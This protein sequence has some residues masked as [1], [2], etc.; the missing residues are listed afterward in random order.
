MEI[1]QELMDAV[2]K[3]AFSEDLKQDFYVWVLEAEDGSI[4]LDQ[5]PGRL[6]ATVNRYI[7]HMASNEKWKE[8]NRLRLLQENEQTVRDLYTQNDEYA[9]D[10]ADIVGLDQSMKEFLGTLSD[11]YR[12]TFEKL[13]LEGYTPEDL[14][15]EEGVARNAIDQRVH[16]IKQLVKEKFNV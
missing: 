15:F 10:P 1:T 9:E 3:S 14:A 7:W 4:D 11:T 8:E 13:Y 16:N 6:R 12:R 2:D 5:K